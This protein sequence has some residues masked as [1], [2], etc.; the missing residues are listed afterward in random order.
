MA[1]LKVLLVV[2]SEDDGGAARSVRLLLDQ[3]D[4]DLVD[5]TLVVHRESPIWSGVPHH[6]VPELVETPTRPR[7]DRFPRSIR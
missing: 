4:R 1:A 2:N 6:V 5:P 7:P 3:F